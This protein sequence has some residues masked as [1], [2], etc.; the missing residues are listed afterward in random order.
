M[1]AGAVTS[2]EVDDGQNYYEEENWVHR[3]PQDDGNGCNGESN[4][5]VDEHVCA[6]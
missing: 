3:Q 4:E 1:T 5:C 2:D 6:S